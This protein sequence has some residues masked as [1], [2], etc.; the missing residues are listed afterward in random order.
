MRPGTHRRPRQPQPR[1]GDRP[2]RPRCG[3]RPG[4]DQRRGQ[5]VPAR[6]SPATGGPSSRRSSARRRSTRVHALALSA[7]VGW[8]AEQVATADDAAWEDVYDRVHRWVRAAAPPRRRRAARV[9]H[10]QRGPARPACSARPNGERTLTDLRHI[11][12][13]L[14]GEAVAGGLGVTA[15]ASWLRR[16]I[17]RGPTGRRQRGPQPA[18]GVGQRGGAGAD[19]STAARA[20]SSRSCTARTCGTRDGSTARTRPCSTTR[21]TATG[22]R[23]TSVARTGPDFSTNRQR[24]VDEERG[25]ELRLA[26]VALTRARHQAVVW[27][28]TSFGSRESALGRLL[29]APDGS[30]L[31]TPPSE[32]QV[33]ARVAG[34]RRQGA[35]HAS[36]SSAARAGPAHAGR[37]PRPPAAELGVRTFDRTL[38]SWWRRVVV[39]RADRRTPRGR[40]RQRAGG[41][42]D[43]RRAAP[44]RHRPVERRPDPPHEPAL[45]SVQLPLAAMPGGARVGSLVHAVLERVD[46]AAPDLAGTIA[47]ELAER[48]AWSRVDVGPVD[49][50]VDGLVAAIETPLGPLAGEARLRDVGR[51][52]RLDELGFELPLVG[53]DAPTADLT[54]TALADVLDAHVGAGDPLDGYATRLRDPLLRRRLRGF[55]N[56]SLD[57]VL[58][59]VDGDGTPRFAV[60]DYKTNWLGV[61]GEELT[62]WHYRPDSLTVAMHHA[63]YPLQ[64]LFYVVALHRYL[65][66][67]LPGYRPEDHLA[68]VLYLFLRGM[69]GRGRAAGRR[70]AVRRVLVVSPAGAR[71]RRER[72]ARHRGAG[73]DDRHRRRSTPGWRS[74]A[75]GLLAEFNRAGVLAAADVHVASRLGALAGVD[76]EA[77][78]LAVALAVRAPRLAHVCVD[79]ATVR[80]TATTDLD[81]PVDVQALPWPDVDAWI[82]ALS[83]SPLVAAGDD[84]RG[85]PPAAPRRHAAVPRPL[86]A[87]GAPRRRR[88]ARPRRPARRPDRRG[89]ARPL[90]WTATSTDRSPISSGRLRRPPCATG[91]PSSPADRAPARRRRSPASSPSSTSRPPQA[92]RRPPR[93]A[94]AA[95]DGQGGGPA[96]GG[97]A[98]R[99]GDDAGRRDGAGSLDGTAG[100]DA[101]PPPRI[102][103][104]QPQ[105]L[106]PQPPQPAAPRR[107]RRRRDLDG[108]AVADGQA[109][110]GGAHRRPPRPR[111]RPRPARLGG[112]RG[113]ARRHRRPG[114]RPTTA[115]AAPRSATGSSCCAACHR[116][117]GGIAALAAAIQRGD[118]DATIDGAR[119]RRH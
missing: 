93:V 115:G 83:A 47:A 37:R 86:L 65:R 77:V 36:P 76:D 101:A 14:H 19:R 102:P 7:F 64:A 88:P 79:L 106:P 111:R 46:F 8:P 17:V 22:E 105:P 80:E 2:R 56:G 54:L 20:S 33:V 109:R 67:R 40:R 34:A 51:A 110:R 1:R 23:S 61:D 85:G 39:H 24:Y 69:T 95:P 66:W 27:W 21:R 59:L 71:R 12:Q 58:R 63:H 15:L 11:G 90:G 81:E 60:V 62:A 103:A 114:G 45:R 92:G 44:D 26:Y 72:P 99:G 112:G 87:P 52:D 35:R 89:A 73:R 70:S 28:A 98:H 42:R 32:Q 10:P 31:A 55:L 4:R 94:L 43:H 82:A 84:G 38:D 108:V 118:A 113:G 5:R 3:R 116:F 18:A 41:G 9:D 97:G 68:G 100:V 16:R 50:V 48:L 6:R 53:G 74:A 49:A 25:E 119:R 104:R 96:R 29:F 107:R 117:G 30:A 75:T 91:S 13:L 57:L 78:L